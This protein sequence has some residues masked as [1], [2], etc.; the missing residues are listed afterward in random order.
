MHYRRCFDRLL[1]CPEAVPNE[2]RGHNHHR[3]ARNNSLPESLARQI[4]LPDHRAF[5]HAHAI[6]L[7]V[8]SGNRIPWAEPGGIFPGEWTMSG[9][10]ENC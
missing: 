4:E 3:P 6:L 8:S 9:I 7:V 2:D 10:M 5:L 1:L